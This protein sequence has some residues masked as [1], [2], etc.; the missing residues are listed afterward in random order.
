MLQ[1]YMK[2]HNIN[3]FKQLESSNVGFKKFFEEVFTD[4][5]NNKNIGRLGDFLNPKSIA[6]KNAL[7]DFGGAFEEIK[8]T[9]DLANSKAS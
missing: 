1:R 2:D 6:G 5:K 8:E 9:I 7:I 3:Y 4:P